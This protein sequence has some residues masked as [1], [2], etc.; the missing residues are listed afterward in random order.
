[1]IKLGIIGPGLIWEK[2]H[3]E[4]LAELHTLFTVV[5]VAGRSAESQHKARVAYPEA[6]IYSQADDLIADPAVE[7]VAILT[8]IDLNAPMALKVLKAGKH[9]IVEKPLAR[10]LSEGK[11]LIRQGAN[12]N[13]ILYILEQHVH[14]SLVKFLKQ[15]IGTEVIG[16]PVAF[17]YSLHCRIAADS[18][19]QTGGYGNTEWRQTPNFPLGNFFDGGIHEIALLSELFGPARSVFAR[20][21]SLR[22]GFGDVDLIS[23]L[24]NY[25][26]GMQGSFM[27]SSFLGKQE[28]FFIIRST[29][30]SLRCE[31]SRIT[32]I[33]AVVGTESHFEF[34]WKNENL[35][36][37]QEVA[38]VIHRKRM[39]TYNL[40]RALSD[41]SLL[42][43]IETSIRT[44]HVVPVD[45]YL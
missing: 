39:P 10:S 4:I 41:L 8:P 12:A 2:T 26:T 15:L 13:Q 9:A 27:H 34:P 24:L 17:E 7:A 3:K 30:A 43:A 29:D 25:D 16:K 20:G 40:Q 22:E 1:M 14:K 37:W 31:N 45:N 5:A 19:D 44:E 28:D 38:D 42:E 18:E 21:R 11:E 33:D 6:R 23:M 35:T 36:M 32:R